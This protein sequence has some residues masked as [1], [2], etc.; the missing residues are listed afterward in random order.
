MLSNVWG[1]IRYAARTLRRNPGFTLAAVVPIALGIG[2]NTGIF[3]ILEGV[4]L[5][6][7]PAPESAELVSIYQQLRGVKGR[8]IN[9]SPSM[10]SCRSIDLS[11]QYET[12]SGIMA[13]RDPGTLR[14]AG[15]SARRRGQT[16]QLQYLMCCSER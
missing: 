15:V 7:L 1:D 6:P 4:A 3:S 12:L 9:G 14:W 13:T 11:R 16:R 8:Y 5:R 2:I 10:L